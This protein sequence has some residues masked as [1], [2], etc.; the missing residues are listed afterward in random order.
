[1]DEQGVVALIT[2][3]K[4][5]EANEGVKGEIVKVLFRFNCFNFLFF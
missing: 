3:D 4:E 5:K 2:G 1:M